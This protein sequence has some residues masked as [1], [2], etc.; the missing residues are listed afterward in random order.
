MASCLNNAT[1]RH[2]QAPRADAV[3]RCYATYLVKVSVLCSLVVNAD[4]E[5]QR[6]AKGVFGSIPQFLQDRLTTCCCEAGVEGEASSVE[7]NFGRLSI[8]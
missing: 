6:Y 3:S 2:S 1:A 4:G 7:S 5:R 8:W